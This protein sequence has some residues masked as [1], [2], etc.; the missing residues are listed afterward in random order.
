ME[1]LTGQVTGVNGNMTNVSFDGSVR[2]NEVAYV[3][4]G[5]QGR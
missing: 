3:I 1:I 5:D 4:V 2:K